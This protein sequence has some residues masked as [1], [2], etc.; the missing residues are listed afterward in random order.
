MKHPYKTVLTT[1]LCIFIGIPLTVIIALRAGDTNLYFASVIVML[2]SMIP[3]FVSFESKRPSPKELSTIAV[4]TAVASVSR[5]AFIYLP[6]FKPMGGVIAVAALAY[7]PAAGIMIG[8]VSMII[9]NMVFGQGPWTVWQMF[10]Y[11]MIGFTA[12]LL[13][14]RRIISEKHAVRSAVITFIIDFVLSGLI[15]DTCSVFYLRQSAATSVAAIYIAGIPY[16][17]LNAAASAICVFLIIK[18]FMIITNRI[19]RKW[20]LRH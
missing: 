10:C 2:L 16:N 17:M 8:A 12:G 6:S 5:I 11:G 1:I 19:N 18:P 14:R 13:G 20:G 3:F 15:L 7:G 4:M 9:S